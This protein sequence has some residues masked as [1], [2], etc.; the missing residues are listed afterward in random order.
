MIQVGWAFGTMTLAVGFDFASKRWEQ[1]MEKRARA[2]KE[3]IT[4]LGPTFIKV[5][6]ALSTRPDL[7]PPPYLF[8]M[9]L[10]QDSL[11]PFSSDVAY[12]IIEEELGVSHVEQVYSEIGAQPVAAASLGQVYKGR[13]LTGEEVAIK[14]QRPNVREMISQDMY[15]ARR[16]AVVLEVVIRWFRADLDLDLVSIVE[17]FATQI[18]GELDFVQEGKNAEEFAALYSNVKNVYVPKIYWDLTRKRLLT[19]EWV[20]GIKLTE[21]EA[22]EAQG[23]ETRE[24]IEILI[25]CSIRQLL[26]KGFFHADPHPGNLLARPDGKLAFLDFGMV[27]YM[28]PYQRYGLL[29]AIVHLVNRDFDRLGD[30]YVRLG[31]LDP[32]TDLSPISRALAKTL[33]DVLSQSVNKLNFKTVFD[34][35]GSIMFEFSFHVPPFYT[36]IVRCLG[37]LEGLALSSS[38]DFKI[39]QNAYPYVSYRLLTDENLRPCLID[40]L[41]NDGRLRWSRMEDLLAQARATNDLDVGFLLNDMFDYILSDSGSDLR[42]MLVDETVELCDALAITGGTTVERMVR[43]PGPIFRSALETLLKRLDSPH[44]LSIGESTSIVS[45]AILVELTKTDDDFYRD[46]PNNAVIRGPA[47][48]NNE[49]AD[50]KL[51][52]DGAYAQREQR[53]REREAL[54]KENLRHIAN[55]SRMLQETPSFDMRLLQ[56]LLSVLLEKRQET[57][58]FGTRVASGLA[59]RYTARALR[60]LLLGGDD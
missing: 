46:H 4:R 44:V 7:L 3:H 39:I 47:L 25:Q 35:L 36:A 55:I 14:L 42:G 5:G 9:S 45:E 30:V 18:F 26:E 34:E 59:D 16:L 23:L 48:L 17:E 27:S 52:F 20:D 10:L 41:F 11:P 15:V 60:R 58:T 28:E 51:A 54:R 31:F 43:D 38:P 21:I 8:Q 2:L 56:Q 29:E 24:L 6:Q 19:M 57:F 49:D 22:I 50:L 40:L 1:N 37:V 33:P 13:L 32:G 12:R 53:R